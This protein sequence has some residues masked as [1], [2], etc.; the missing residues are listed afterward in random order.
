[1][2][3]LKLSIL[4]ALLIF[5]TANDVSAKDKGYWWGPKDL[6]ERGKVGILNRL[7]LGYNFTKFGAMRLYTEDLQV[8]INSNDATDRKVIRNEKY[9]WKF[10]GKTQGIAAGM[11]F[12]LF[13]KQTVNGLQNYHS[14][15]S[16]YTGLIVNKTDFDSDTFRAAF[17]VDDKYK[18]LFRTIDVHTLIGFDY[19]YG[20]DAVNKRISLAMY[21]IGAGVSPSLMLFMYTRDK[22]IDRMFQ[23]RFRPYLKGEFGLFLGMAVKFRAVIMGRTDHFVIN[24][25]SESKTHESKNYQQLTSRAEFNFSV[26]IMPFSAGWKKF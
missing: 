8:N 19:K 22:H 5:S 15:F 13:K 1:M 26:I 4:G 6:E 2:N 7:E 17:K 11:A 10:E 9:R 12:P 24:N 21:G 20:A 16:L 14:A 3:R 25:T 23:P 18:F